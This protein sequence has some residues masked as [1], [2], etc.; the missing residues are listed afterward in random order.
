MTRVPPHIR[1]WVEIDLGRLELNVANVRAALPNH[2]SYIAVV[3][4]DA[5]GHGLEPIVG[6]L[7][8]AGADVFAVA[9]LGE[10]AAIRE[11]GRGWPI[12]VLSALLP[13]EE[14]QAVALDVMPTISSL[15]EI[16][17]LERAADRAR[18]VLQVH[19]KID[20]G[21]G[22]LGVWHPQA[23]QVYDRLRASRGLKLAGIFTHF[24]CAD[25]DPDFTARQRKL[26]LN[27]LGSLP[28]WDDAP[29]LIHADNSAGLHSFSREGPF[30]G[31]RVGL[32]QF[33]V[34]RHPRSL[35]A[36]V[37]VEPVLSFHTRLSLIKTLPAQTGI[38]YGLTFRLERETRVGVLAAGYGD[39]IPTAL[40]N[41]GHVIV[42]GHKCPILGRVTMDQTVID[43]SNVTEATPGDVAT[44]IGTQEDI[45]LTA[46]EF[47]LQSNQIPWE[48][49]CAITRRV[50]R[51]Y[52]SDTAM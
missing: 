10:A 7:M 9:N 23:R 46:A 22:R 41:V 50:H 34:R 13:G 42:R 47:A 1:A 43:L 36:A 8:R 19:L 45:N 18:R 25:S 30:N 6:R 16:E 52:R 27:V 32:L 49:F 3:K 20:T 24:A 51:F 48:A 5:Y 31:A 26:F 39:G 29:R 37:D 21:M 33:G 44:L 17:R 35:L 14:G 28:G 11:V 38:S 12:L 2:L 15:D 4:A 40:S